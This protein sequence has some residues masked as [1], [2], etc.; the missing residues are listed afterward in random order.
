[1]KKKYPATNPRNQEEN[2]THFLCQ[3]SFFVCLLCVLLGSCGQKKTAFKPAECSFYYWQ[4]TWAW[5][6]QEAQYLKEL[7][8]KELYIRFFDV[9][10]NEYEKRVVPV[11]PLRLAEKHTSLPAQIR[12]IPTIF[13]TNRSM[14]NLQE[15]DVEILAGKLWEKIK[16]QAKAIFPQNH[17]EMIQLDCDWSTETREI[18]FKLCRALKKHILPASLSATIRLHQTKYPQKMGLPP[19]DRGVLMCYNV[20]KI[21]GSDTQNSILDIDILRSYVASLSSYPIK[22]DIALP[23]FAWGVLKRGGKVIKLL[24]GMSEEDLQN[25]SFENIKKQTWRVKKAH[26]NNHTYLYEGDEIRIEKTS[27]DLLQKAL[28]EM[29]P[30]LPPKPMNLIF[31]HLHKSLQNHF[32]IADLKELASKKAI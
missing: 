17:I 21:D 27:L 5:S 4:T 19:I 16:V 14:Y 8:A 12:I 26:Y 32:S 10:W 9:D 31:Y 1:M 28:Q 30:H 11:S 29:S 6:A 23:T 24:N 22:L 13:I 7:D 18:Y 20:G 25:T 15:S 3:N 2:K